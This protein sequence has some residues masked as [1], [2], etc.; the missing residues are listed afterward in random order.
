M[1]SKQSLIPYMSDS[2]KKQLKKKYK[3]LKTIKSE[4][5]IA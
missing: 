2:R 1:S 4:N 3:T 5:M